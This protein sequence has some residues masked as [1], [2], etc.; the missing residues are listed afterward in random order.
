MNEMN[1]KLNKYRYKARKTMK[2]NNND[3]IEIKSGK[4]VKNK[5]KSEKIRIKQGKGFLNK[6]IDYL[7]MEVHMPG[8]QYC[9]PG[10]NLEKRLKR[11][12]PGRNKL[13][14]ACKEHDIAYRDSSDDESRYIAD[15]KLMKAA[16]ERVHSKD[17][18][19][20]EKGIALAVS[21]AMKAKRGLT[22]NPKKSGA[23]INKKKNNKPKKK[24]IERNIKDIKH[25][26]FNKLVKDARE[27]IDKHKPE[28]IQAAI[29]I[30]TEAIAKSLKGKSI[31]KPRTIKT[32]TYSGG[33]L[34]L[35]P[36]FAALGSVVGGTTSIVN[37]INNYRA[38]QKQLDES[39]QHNIK[40]ESIAMGNGYYLK[41]HKNGSGFYLKQSKNL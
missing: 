3:K 24:E 21:G 29:N 31:K 9:G 25:I 17:A 11:G 32:P 35:I 15:E 22:K 27:V 37:A 30:A 2:K 5:R 12:D 14:V 19:Y 38:A 23:G 20:F 39:K 41:T 33:V 26:T 13:D 7:P 40:M 1:E 34:P 4:C 16:M 10:T 6:L 36:F 8:Y 28:N 18:S